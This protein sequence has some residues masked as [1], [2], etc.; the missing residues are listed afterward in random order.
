LKVPNNPKT[1]NA[2][3]K[4]SITFWAWMVSIGV[5]AAVFSV[6]AFV[7]FAQPAV[8]DN[9]QLPIPSA[10]LSSIKEFI[11]AEP[12]IPKPKI[13]SAKQKPASS[14]ARQ[15]AEN[16]TDKIL[17]SNRVF[18]ASKQA[19]QNIA[20]F[21]RPSVAQNPFS[22]TAGQIQAKDSE[23]F[24]NSTGERKIC[25]VVDC[26]GSMQGIFNRV[27]QKLKDS[28]S[29]LQP[30]QYFYIIFFSGNRLIEFGDG[31][32]L[33]ATKQNK[34]EAFGFIDS[35]QPAGTTNAM[36]A[37]EK[38]VQIRDS[39]TGTPSVVYFLT[40]GFELTPEDAQLFSQKLAAALKETAAPVKV[41]TIGFWPQTGDR[42]LLETIAK[43]TGGDFV[44][45]SDGYNWNNGNK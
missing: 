18:A 41:N 37:M 7:K 15:S 17:P 6:F 25:Y 4:G 3:R 1:A 38:V 42:Q 16:N 5:H 27:Q 28:I 35:V 12:V 14:P 23:F 32:L 40:D 24:V 34:A 19:S 8:D 43:Q 26:S 11:E 33:R 45:V 9:R 29:A 2:A 44:L 30:D 31:K 39:H 10:K 21:A 22:L 20:D 13:T 36:A